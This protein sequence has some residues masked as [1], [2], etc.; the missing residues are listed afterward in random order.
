MRCHVIQI[1]QG[2]RVECTYS[3]IETERP[4]KQNCLIQ[5]RVNVVAWV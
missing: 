3:R 1:V 5:P 4:Q 2:R